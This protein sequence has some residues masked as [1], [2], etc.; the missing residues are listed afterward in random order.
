M[1]KQFLIKHL[2]DF[3]VEYNVNPKD[4]YVTHGGAMVLLQLNVSTSDIDLT[5][6]KE[7]YERF[8]N[9]LGFEPIILEPCSTLPEAETLQV[10]DYI[11]LQVETAEQ[12]DYGTLFSENDVQFR[13]MKAT[14]EDYSV[15]GRMKDLLNLRKLSKLITPVD[16][17]R[18]EFDDA[19]LRR[20]IDNNYYSGSLA[21]NTDKPYEPPSFMILGKPK[22]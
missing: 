17:K 9:E 14:Y 8:K 3:F 13:N 12:I 11:F 22:K 16:R 20:A 1:D 19:Q 7:V 4:C 18:T 5:V 21:G 6:T 10:S 2:K 15:L